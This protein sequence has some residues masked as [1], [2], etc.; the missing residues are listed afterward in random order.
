LGKPVVATGVD[1]VV[2]DEEVVVDVRVAVVGLVEVAVRD[3]VVGLTVVCVDDVVLV[4]GVVWDVDGG[5]DVVVGADVRVVVVVV[6]VVVVLVLI[7]VLVLTVV[8]V[9]VVV[10]VAVDPVEERLDVTEV[11]GVE[12]GELLLGVVVEDF[13]GR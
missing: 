11:G 9:V 12:D 13:G 6:V 2:V 8:L 7:L 10:V 1:E 4:G 5:V 3:V